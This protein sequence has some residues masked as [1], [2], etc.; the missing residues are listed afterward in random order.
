MSSSSLAFCVDRANLGNHHTERPLYVRTSARYVLGTRGVLSA[1]QE[2]NATTH[3]G[4][5]ILRFDNTPGG[6]PGSEKRQATQISTRTLAQGSEQDLE[7]R[8]Y[9]HRRKHEMLLKHHVRGRAFRRLVDRPSLAARFAS[10][11]R[12]SFPTLL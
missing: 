2:N 11:L 7:T 10:S 4:R 9:R 1:E 6:G 5:V 8:V 12:P 3:V